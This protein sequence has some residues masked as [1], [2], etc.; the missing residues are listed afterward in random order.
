MLRLQ[1][2]VDGVECDAAAV[3]TSGLAVVATVSA[4]LEVRAAK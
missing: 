4:D 1:L 3:V 2:C